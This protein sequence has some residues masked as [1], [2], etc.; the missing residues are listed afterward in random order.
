M[1]TVPVR[2]KKAHAKLRS[3]VR[4]RSGSVAPYQLLPTLGERAFRSL[5]EDIRI[6]GVLVPIERDEVGALLDGHHRVRAVAELRSEG[7]DVTD[8]PVMVRVGFSELEKR[9]HVRALNLH[10]R[11]LTSA[12]RR[13]VIREQLR[14]TPDRSDRSIARQ[15]GSSHVTVGRER[16]ALQLRVE[17]ATGQVVQF[18]TRVG[19]DGKRRRLPVRT[20]QRTILA[21][22][23]GE[24]KR[25]TRMLHLLGPDD[26]LVLSGTDARR[27]ANSARR[28]LNRAETFRA[29]TEAGPLTGMGRQRFSVIYAD[30]P[31]AYSDGA[32]DPSRRVR[33]QYPTMTLAEIAALPVSDIAASQAVLF[34]F[35]TSP[36][37]YDAM[38][39]L[40]AWRFVYKSS[41]VWN[42]QVAG[43]G[44]W[45]FRIAHEH[46]LVAVRGAMPTPAPATRVNSV[47]SI[48]R[49]A[50]SVKPPEFRKLI[51]RFYPGLPKIELFA[52]RRSPGW[53]AWGNQIPD[54]TQAEHA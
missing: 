15:L 18:A 4:K 24:A 23:E 48:K 10:R 17:D 9:A 5:K 22:D 26:P 54:N 38:R 51:E 8:P 44:S 7:C 14:D 19:D 34:M 41:A 35:T 11:H 53:H 37:L 1:R 12:Q 6:S 42:K 29:L 27:S 40:D 52:R 3:S 49:G 39:V 47:I 30:P 43:M 2:E 46:L 20:P 16:A 45:G 36:F 25:V 28:E 13:A 33:F 32:T 21:M 50:H 31:W